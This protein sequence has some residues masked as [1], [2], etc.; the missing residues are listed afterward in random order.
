M[1]HNV[2]VAQSGGPSPVIN[3]SLRGIIETCKMFPDQF[4]RIYGGWHGIEGVLKEELLD[5]SAQDEEEISLL[6]NTPAAGS[7]GTCRYK[8]KDSQVKDFQR[9]LEVFRT[10]DIGYFFYIGGNDSQHTAFRVSELAKNS[11]LD[12]IAVGV[13]KTID[14]D[15]GDNEF[16][17][18]D[19]TPGYG[20]VARYWSHIIQNANEEN[21]GS[22]PADPVLV[23]QAMGRKIGY[24][25]AASRLADPERKIPLQIYLAESKVPVETL[26]D[27]VN[28]QLKQDGRC[29]VVI[30]E[31]F[32]AGNIGEVKDAFG[33][34]SFGSSKA[35][36][37]QTVVN[38]LNSKG[39]KAKGSARGQVMGTDQRHSAAYA[40]IVDL[41]EAYR[42]GQKAVE[43]ASKEE[44]GWMATILRE[45]GFIYN[46]KYDKVPLQKVA[47]SERSFPEKWIAPSRFDVTDEFLDYVRPLIG[48]DW[49]SVPIINGRQRFSKFQMIFAD[50][51]LPDYLPQAYQKEN[52]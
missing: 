20:S 46:V 6:R 19:H 25:P 28:D 38:Y 30:S 3:S 43:I 33:H 2:I 50:K 5:L 8:L 14:N 24:I 32:D 34:T 16:T 23:I 17:L 27:N 13:P 1:S 42:V 15:L 12:L 37:F 18:I 9:L 40:S 45:P 47:L 48:E 22:S 44:N 35:S 39:L 49:P 21:M 41:D 36:V 11:G 31:G 52:I 26:A 4:G 7:I 51:K 29:I 10:H